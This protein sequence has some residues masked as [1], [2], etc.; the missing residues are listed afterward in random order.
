MGNGDLEMTRLAIIF[1]LLFVTPA[2]AFMADFGNKTCAQNIPFGGLHQKKAKQN[3]MDK[4]KNGDCD[5]I[6]VQ[7]YDEQNLG[8]G[9]LEHIS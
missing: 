6:L 4:I 5:T 1:S 7:S 3:L 2:W 9:A 8:S